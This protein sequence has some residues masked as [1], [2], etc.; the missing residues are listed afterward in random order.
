[1]AAKRQRTETELKGAQTPT[2]PWSQ[3]PSALRREISKLVPGS[4]AGAGRFE[5]KL[6]RDY[7]SSFCGPDRAP[8]VRQ[9]RLGAKH[10][11]PL[12]CPHHP[13]VA[14]M[15]F[16]GP[17]QPPCC[18][19][20][21]L[22][23]PADWEQLFQLTRLGKLLIVMSGATIGSVSIWGRSLGW[24]NRVLDTYYANPQLF[25]TVEFAGDVVDS[26]RDDDFQIDYWKTLAIYRRNPENNVMTSAWPS[27]SLRP[28]ALPIDPEWYIASDDEDKDVE[29]QIIRYIHYEYWKTQ[30]IP[31]A[32]EYLIRIATMASN[33]GRDELS[34][35]LWG[36]VI[37]LKD[38]KADG[39][40][41]DSD[42][43]D[44]EQD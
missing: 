8:Q 37:S 34:K 31:Q 5:S 11:S 29:S 28:D 15:R 14:P 26:Y 21:K 12:I 4:I 9:R 25:D 35:S 32:I 24:E 19:P 20:L 39:E 10:I 43:E 6:A 38:R 44:D 3:L 40:F 42:T 1:M 18:L 2:S 22:E 33:Y 23:S 16:N 36:E 27:A 30:R 7:R 13:L 41:D 17:L